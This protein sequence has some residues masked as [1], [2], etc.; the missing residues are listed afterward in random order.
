MRY[1]DFS[2]LCVSEIMTRW[3]QTIRVFLDL[4]MHCVGCPIGL[5]HTLADAA[6]EHRLD[7]DQL[8]AAIAAAIEGDAKAGRARGRRQSTSTGADP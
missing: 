3:P 6:D 1:Q 4:R 7:L 8:A 2:D 5:F